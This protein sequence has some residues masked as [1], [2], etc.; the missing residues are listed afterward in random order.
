[1]NASTLRSGVLAVLALVAFPFVLAASVSAASVPA[2]S[3][4]AAQDAGAPPSTSIESAR[5]R[6]QK[7]SPERRRE[8][9]ERFERWR[10]MSEEERDRMRDRYHWYD[11]MRRSECDRLP[12]SAKKSLEGLDPERRCEA[13]HGLLSERI[14]E[15][16]H[17]ILDMLPPEWREKLER[18]SPEERQRIV[19]EFKERTRARALARIDDLAREGEIA[20]EEAERLRGLA[21]NALVGELVTVE[22]R[23]IERRGPPS[24]VNAEQ[25]DAWKALPDRQFFERWNEVRRR[26]CS[27]GG[28]GRSRWHEEEAPRTPREAQLRE[29]QRSLWPES[30]WWIEVSKL[31]MSREQRREQ[32]GARR[33]V[34]VLEVLARSP[35]LASSAQVEE[36]RALEGE[37]FF[38]ALEKVVPEIELPHA[39]RSCE[40]SPD[41][42]TG[43]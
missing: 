9:A 37:A 26:S 12:D 31:P 42:R 41:A 43:Q 39:T 19:E 40:T 24:H 2:A 34:Q 18:A 1:M 20:P 5:E 14:S 15:R 13:I 21:P 29:L 35:E 32:V 36:L 28:K 30:A 33:R 11:R 17:A 10:S 6:W 27:S 25:W 4:P 8:L 7:L 16:G 3:A 38:E 22:R 23:R